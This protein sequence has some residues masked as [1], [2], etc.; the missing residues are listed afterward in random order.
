LA[1]EDHGHRDDAEGQARVAH[2]FQRRSYRNI[3]WRRNSAK[4]PTVLSASH[5]QQHPSANALI[6]TTGERQR[7]PRN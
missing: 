4:A 2:L 5:V 3:G 6:R 1:R 7:C